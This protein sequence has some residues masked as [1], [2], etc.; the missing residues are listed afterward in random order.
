MFD[1]VLNMSMIN[2][3]VF[4]NKN[5]KICDCFV[6]GKQQQNVILTPLLLNSNEFH[7]FIVAF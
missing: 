5:T 6:Q 1:R 4:N 7:F 3:I 2:W